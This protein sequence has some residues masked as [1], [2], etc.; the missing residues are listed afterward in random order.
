M[1]KILPPTDVNATCFKDG[2]LRYSRV[3]A[4][5]IC[6]N[7]NSTP[8]AIQSDNSVQTFHTCF[9]TRCGSVGKD[10]RAHNYILLLVHNLYSYVQFYDQM[11][12][13]LGAF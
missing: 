8:S 2:T 13:Q 10:L 6:I 9:E 12:D 5:T 4:D 7:T 11:K 1:I 3:I